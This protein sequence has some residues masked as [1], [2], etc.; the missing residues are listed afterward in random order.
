MSATTEFAP[1]P[2]DRDATTNLPTVD[3]FVVLFES[4]EAF[5]TYR[6]S[7]DHKEVGVTLSALADWLVADYPE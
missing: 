4:E 5:E 1:A 7:A 6:Q 3:S 2:L